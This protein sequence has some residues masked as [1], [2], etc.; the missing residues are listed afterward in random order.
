MRLRNW[1]YGCFW[2]VVFC[3]IIRTLSFLSL[4]FEIPKNTTNRG[5]SVAKVAHVTETLQIIGF[6]FRQFPKVGNA[7]YF[8]IRS[9]VLHAY[10]LVTHIHIVR[11]NKTARGL[12]HFVYRNWSVW[13]NWHK[14]LERFRSNARNSLISS[15]T[16]KLK[17]G[18]PLKESS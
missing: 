15:H 10:A 17:W 1:K 7:T 4:H 13:L 5:V 11:V 6:L 12:S 3:S 18:F 14:K 2:S 16:C 9:V 8:G